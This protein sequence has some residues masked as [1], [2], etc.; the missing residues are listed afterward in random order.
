MNEKKLM[1][2]VRQRQVDDVKKTIE[3]TKK[4]ID[5]AIAKSNQK[6]E[7]MPKTKKT[8]RVRLNKAVV[9]KLNRV[10][11]PENDPKKKDTPWV[12]L[13]PGSIQWTVCWEKNK[14]CHEEMLKYRERYAVEHP[15]IKDKGGEAMK[16]MKK[17]EEELK[18][19]EKFVKKNGVE[20]RRS[21]G[22]GEAALKLDDDDE[23]DDD[24]DEET[25]ERKPTKKATLKVVKNKAAKSAREVMNVSK[26]FGADGRTIDLYAEDLPSNIQTVK[27]LIK[28]LRESGHRI[29]ELDTRSNVLRVYNNTRVTESG[30]VAKVT[31]HKRAKDIHV[32]YRSNKGSKTV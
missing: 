18:Q 22:K 20:K 23:F 17:R 2:M 8:V 32:S 1:E 24:E 27:Q 25:I 13:V 9:D 4:A 11:L 30:R 6:E 31:A 5:K 3:S 26:A 19:I 29:I 10:R 16:A 7:V 28:Y 12:D 21:A 14:T 15:E